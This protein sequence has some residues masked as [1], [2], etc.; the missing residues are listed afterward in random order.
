MEVVMDIV[1]RCN[2]ACPSCPSG[3]DV[4]A[5][6]AGKLEVM[7]VETFKAV[8]AKLN[9]D[10]SGGFR[11]HLYNWSEPLLHP[12]FGEL[13]RVAQ[14]ADVRCEISSNLNVR[15]DFDWVR[16]SSALKRMFVSVSGFT[17][18]TYGKGHRGGSIDLVKQNLER[19]I[20][21][22]PDD[23][24]L[25]I[26]VLF[27]RY[28]HNTEDEIAFAEYCA[29][30]NISFYPYFAYCAPLNK[31]FRSQR[32]LVDPGSADIETTEGMLCF[33]HKTSPE[34]S[35]SFRTLPCFQQENFIVLNHKAQMY[36]CCMTNYSP[37]TLVGE[38]LHEDLDSL[39]D[40]KRALPICGECKEMGLH[41]SFSNQCHFHEKIVEGV[42][43]R[44]VSLDRNR[45]G[46]LDDLFT[47]T[48]V[49]TPL[50]VLGAGEFGV[51][52][53][54]TL[55]ALGYSVRAIADDS[56]VMH[57]KNLAGIPVVAPQRALEMSGS[58]G[59]LILG[60]KRSEQEMAP[61]KD[62]FRSTG[63][64]AVHTLQSFATAYYV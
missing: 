2:L 18:Q 5:K 29:Q 46:E 42:S 32:G 13:L 30:K 8:V 55:Q 7:P 64:A 50:V 24:D 21:L 62:K 51:F 17:Q 26:T 53:A 19:I 28:V 4:F 23:S 37:D 54:H 63:W 45:E 3:R 39:I 34:A 6:R 48:P 33:T 20:A 59:M 12:Q 60:L 52:L 11:L 47:W 49:E 56:A 15:R 36:A 61:L 31:H 41:I 38:Y 25:Q 16:E 9:D 22:R 44:G 14:E 10:L 1:S 57:G 40:K 58:D 43:S 35:R 27:H